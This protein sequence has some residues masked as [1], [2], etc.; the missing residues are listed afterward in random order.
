MAPVPPHSPGLLSLLGGLVLSAA[1]GWLAYRR[2]S[3]SASG[4]VGAIVTG[5]ILF[6]VGGWDWGLLLLTFFVSSSLLSHYRSADKSRLAEKF[7]KG[8]QRD[9]GQ[10]LANAGVASL[11]ALTRLVWDHP[12]LYLGCA[13][14][15]AAVNAD[16]WSTELG[17]L[18]RRPPRLI[19]TGRQVEV[20]TSGGVTGLGL[21]ATALGGTLIGLAGAAAAAARG[22]DVAYAA[23]V[24]LGAVGGGVAGSLFDSLLGATAQAIYWCDRCGKETERRVHRCGAATRRVRGLPWLG[25]DGVNLLASAVGAAVALGIGGL[26]P[27]L[28]KLVVMFWI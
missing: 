3:L 9:L 27:L 8:H 10:A 12:L 7:A 25:N 22:R 16:T 23:A 4:V 18:S 21:A 13:G 26:F 24:L 11:L 2:R 28:G 14:A 5:T 6:G 19:T 20:G 15:M 17:V 1:V